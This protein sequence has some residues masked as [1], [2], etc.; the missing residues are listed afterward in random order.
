MNGVTSA[1]LP[2]NVGVPQGSSLGPL[3]YLLSVNSI[4]EY[5][6]SNCE[7]D[8]NL[9]LFADDTT[10][11][12]SA[13]DLDTAKSQ[14]DKGLVKL[15]NYF[16]SRGLKLNEKKSQVM[17]VR[18]GV[19]SPVDGEVC[20]TRVQNA[21][22]LLGVVIDNRL[23]F[24]EHMDEV[25]AKLRGR[26]RMLHRTSKFLGQHSRKTLFDTLI[27]PVFQYS[28]SVFCGCSSEIQRRR[29]VLQRL[30]MKYILGVP[31]DYSTESLYD[32]LD[33]LTSQERSKLHLLSMVHKILNSGGPLYLKSKLIN[34]DHQHLTRL[35]KSGLVITRG[36]DQSFSSQGPRLWNGLS[37][38]IRSC[39]DFQM[40][41]NRV[42]GFLREMRSV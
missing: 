22:K 27:L 28:D 14:C 41:R 23:K 15:T 8:I 31:T 16:S 17:I 6:K 3:L 35:S 12:V 30:G 25:E 39:K 38:E 33:Y 26:L 1:P 37:E 4:N 42:F 29:E 36:V 9:I 21:I 34:P 24:D 11:C 20:G 10:M 18:K 19:K 13:P 5:V 7:G 40:F 2:N 32:R